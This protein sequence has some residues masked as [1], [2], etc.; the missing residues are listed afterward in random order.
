[1]GFLKLNWISIGGYLLVAGLLWAG[2]H[3][4]IV[5]PAVK[6]AVERSTSPLMVRLE[7]QDATMIGQVESLKKYSIR[8]GELE[9]AIVSKEAAI[10]ANDNLYNAQVTRLQMLITELNKQNKQLKV[11]YRI[12]LVELKLNWT[13]K[14]LVDSTYT[15][16][17]Y[18]Y[19][20]DKIVRNVESKRTQ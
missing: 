4:L 1:M 3:N 14:K 13:K 12:D 8:I 9:S 10:V 19:Q 15:K 20:G 16:N 17:A 2:V 7:K 6:K 11:G 5:S 18:V